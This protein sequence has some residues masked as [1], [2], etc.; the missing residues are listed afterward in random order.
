M[1]ERWA[2]LRR[3]LRSLVRFVIDFW[4]DPFTATRRA[5]KRRTWPTPKEFDAMS[6]E[7]FVAYMEK[8]RMPT[9]ADGCSICG[10]DD[11]THL[12]VAG[13]VARTAHLPIVSVL[14]MPCNLVNA[15]S[16]ALHR[17]EAQA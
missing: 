2:E 17:A 3:A 12:T 11:L 6:Q 1:S 14:N 15:L 13:F 4:Y 8:I 7:D 5:S 16:R 9:I 10:G